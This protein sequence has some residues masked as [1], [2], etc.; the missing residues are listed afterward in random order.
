MNPYTIDDVQD[1][2]ASVVDRNYS[3]LNKLFEGGMKTIS[4]ELFSAGIITIDVQKE[5]TFEGILSCF[6]AG[7]AFKSEVHEL[8]HYCTCF[9]KAFYKA[10]GP[11]TE[12]ADKLKAEIVSDVKN[13]FGIEMKIN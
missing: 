9:F 5:P 13:K 2:I 3:R 7:F 12:A 10:G 4:L 6:R 1:C 8:E 11:F